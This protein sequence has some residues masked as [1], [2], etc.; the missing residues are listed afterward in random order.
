MQPSDNFVHFKDLAEEYN[1]QVA[2]ARHRENKHFT[3]MTLWRKNIKKG[4]DLVKKGQIEEGL[5]LIETEPCQ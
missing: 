1:K 4:V 5:L 2:A 3:Y